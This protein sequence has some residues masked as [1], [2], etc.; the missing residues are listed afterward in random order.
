MNSQDLYVAIGAFWSV[1][2]LIILA[3][4]RILPDKFSYDGDFIQR[5]ANGTGIARGDNSYTNTGAFYRILNLEDSPILSGL[6]GLT[7]FTLLCALVVS[8]SVRQIYWPASLAVVGASTIFAAVYLGYYSKEIIVLAIVAT[9]VAMPER[10]ECE[11][12][13]I[14]VMLAYAA[15]FRP[16]WMIIA[17]IYAICRL[18][19]TRSVNLKSL[20]TA[21]VIVLVLISVVFEVGLGV[22]LDYYRQSVND[23]RGAG[24]DSITRIEPYV[25]IAPSQLE[26][27]VNVTITLITL[28]FPFPLIF[29]GSAYYVGIVCSVSVVW[30]TFLL[31]V[32]RLG[33]GDIVSLKKTMRLSRCISLAFAFIVVQA[34]FEPDFG[35]AVRHQVPIMPA[36]LLVVLAAPIQQTSGQLLYFRK[37]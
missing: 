32:S 15:L 31:A 30:L 22:S 8:K 20:L 25:S 26:S 28:F 13:I 36:V 37:K 19:P 29:L 1:G 23:I 9:I 27:V 34:L 11:V 18:L 7:A 6:L 10:V 5:I 35:S 24:S 4:D 16:Y 21:S 3:R 17:A 33:A 2:A 12:A 14:A